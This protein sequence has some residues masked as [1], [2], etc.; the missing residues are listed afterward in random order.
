MIECE[1]MCKEYDEVV[2]QVKWGEK[3]HGNVPNHCK[4]AVAVLLM[5]M[6]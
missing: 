4:I 1:A 5:Y 3:V 2:E 6:R